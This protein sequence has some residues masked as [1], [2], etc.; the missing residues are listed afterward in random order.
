MRAAR[1]LPT[2]AT[3]TARCPQ[4]V[5]SLQPLSE[6]VTGAAEKIAEFCER[7]PTAI[8]ACGCAA[9]I[10]EV[11]AW[12]WFFNDRYEGIPISSYTVAV[13]P[14]GDPGAV[15]VAARTTDTWASV[16]KGFVVAAKQR[17]R[18]SFATR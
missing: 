8:E 18:V 2:V 17:R 14:K 9:D 3:I 4:V 13:A 12:W 10:D 6:R 1:D 7:V 15:A 11:E 5:A 16:S